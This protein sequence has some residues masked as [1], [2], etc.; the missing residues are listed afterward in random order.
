MEVLVALF[1]WY[2]HYS[3]NNEELDNHHKTLFDIFNKLYE[4]CLDANKSNCID[5]IIK[6][7]V[8]YSSYHF[9]AE[10]QHMRDIGYQEID[11]HTEEHRTFTDRTFQLQQVAGKDG[12]EAIKELIEYLGTWLLHHVLDED[13][14]YSI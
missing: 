7:L 8:S 10:E 4:T 13:K 1:T 14:K 12:P 6:K 3:V 5:P 9:S 2:K 11:K